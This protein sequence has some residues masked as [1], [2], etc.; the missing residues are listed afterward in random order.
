MKRLPLAQPWMVQ[1]ASR[2]RPPP[3]QRSHESDDTQHLPHTGRQSSCPDGDLTPAPL[4]SAIGTSRIH[5]VCPSSFNGKDCSRQS[6]RPSPSPF[7]LGDTAPTPARPS[8]CVP[9]AIPPQ[10]DRQS[11]G[12]CRLCPFSLPAARSPFCLP[13]LLAVYAY[14]CLLIR[15]DRTSFP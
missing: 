4:F 10:R 5:R 6:P 7:S 9:C 15:R 11:L 12:P 2:C 3:P 8:P 13:I 14:V 1:S